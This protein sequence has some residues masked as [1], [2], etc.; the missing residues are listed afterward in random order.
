LLSFILSV[1][2]YFLK[3]IEAEQCALSYETI[4]KITAIVVLAFF[5]CFRITTIA[6]IYENVPQH[7]FLK[8]LIT[9]ITYI[10]Y[11]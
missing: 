1:P 11:N 5:G 10:T 4:E 9:L 6:V 2:D 8:L 7:Q 3:L